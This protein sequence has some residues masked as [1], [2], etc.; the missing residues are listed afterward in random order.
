[1]LF[2]FSNTFVSMKSLKIPKKLSEA[3]V[4]R[5]TTYNTI[6]NRQTTNN[7]LQNRTQKT[8]D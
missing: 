3:A 6:A 8:K 2:S 1:M 7:D 5:K 4:N